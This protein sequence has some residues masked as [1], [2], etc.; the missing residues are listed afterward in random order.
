MAMAMAMP[1]HAMAIRG[2]CD[3]RCGGARGRSHKNLD[4]VSPIPNDAQ[5]ADHHTH[6]ISL[7]CIFILFSFSQIDSAPKKEGLSDSMKAR[8]MRE[9]STGLDADKKQT[10]VL[11]YII[12][13]VA[14]LVVAGGAGIF[15]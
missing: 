2:R 9:A 4:C 14:L 10:N 6:P 12:V 5:L 8:L 1:C 15:Y 3:I 11:L 7:V 13:A